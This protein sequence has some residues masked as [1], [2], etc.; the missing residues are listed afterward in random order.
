MLYAPVEQLLPLVGINVFDELS[1]LFSTYEVI[2]DIQTWYGVCVCDHSWRYFD[3]LTLLEFID[4]EL[5]VEEDDYT[6][7]IVGAGES[8]VDA[9]GT[10]N[11]AT[12]IARFHNF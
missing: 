4:S 10:V 5:A 6:L 2:V 8:K 9:V 3:I 7:W 11:K 12:L 1:F